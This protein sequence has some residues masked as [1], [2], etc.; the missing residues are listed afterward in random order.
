MKM[1]VKLPQKKL[2]ATAEAAKIYG[3]S[4]AHI[5]GMASRGE[6]WSQKITERSWLYDA[7]EIRDL[8][9]QRE[10]LRVAGKLPGR[11]PGHM[12]SA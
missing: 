11:R 1:P 10:Q 5:R 7:D 6:I 9:K 12:K 3:C 8:A 2:C 4:A